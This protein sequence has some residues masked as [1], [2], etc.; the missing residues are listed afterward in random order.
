MVIRL[1][2]LINTVKMN[3]KNIILRLHKMLKAEKEQ[4]L[5]LQE[6][7]AP[8][9]MKES[10]NREISRLVTRIIEYES[11]CMQNNLI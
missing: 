2:L 7:E 5:F 6:N 4:L 8:E 9:C 11:Y 3:W 1:L 10:C